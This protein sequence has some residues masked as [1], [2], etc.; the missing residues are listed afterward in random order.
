MGENIVSSPVTVPSNY[1]GCCSGNIVKVPSTLTHQIIRNWDYKGSNGANHEAIM[2]YINPSAGT[3]DWSTFDQLFSN[4]PDKDIVFV[5]GNPPDY[6]V[7]RSAVGGAY[8][9]TKGNMCPDDLTG[10]ATA[11]QAVVTRALVTWGRSGLKWELWNEF[12]QTSCYNDTLSLLGPYTRITANAIKLIDPTA[13]ILSPS[14]AGPD[15]TKL[16]KMV[17]YVLLSDGIGTTTAKWLDGMTYHYYNQTL[18]F[19]S[20]N[21]HPISYVNGVRNFQGYLKA[22]GVSLPIWITETGCLTTDTNRGLAYQRRL[23]T[24]AAM[25]AQ[26][27]LLY[28]YDAS[29]YLVSAFESQINE[30]AALLANNAVITS[31]IPGIA[32]MQITINGTTYTY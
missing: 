23:L 20:Q 25:G 26:C 5:L 16:N 19:V 3:Y 13:V 15:L 28:Q 9:G 1:V 11:V 8:R 30:V 21:E 17:S 4:N 32:Q 10:W 7:T 22:N 29:L 6:L 2:T 24:F 12:D 27:C 18:S 14:I 31:C